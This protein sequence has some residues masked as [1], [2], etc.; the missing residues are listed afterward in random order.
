[1]KAPNK[2]SKQKKKTPKTKPTT[3]K[4]PDQTCGKGIFKFLRF[5]AFMYD[6]IWLFILREDILFL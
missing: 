6:I 1:M 2:T 3:K 5:Q 4:N